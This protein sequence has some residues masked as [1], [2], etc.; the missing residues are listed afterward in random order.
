MKTI[1]KILRAAFSL[2]LILSLFSCATTKSAGAGSNS[3]S[4]N[5][6]AKSSSA[7]AASLTSPVT[8]KGT[9]DGSLMTVTFNT[10]GTFDMHTNVSTEE[11]GFSLLMDLDVGK[12]TFTGDPSTDGEITMTVLKVA[13][14]DS[15]EAGDIAVAKMS[16]VLSSG[17]NTIEITNDD[18][19][20]V[21]YKGSAKDQTMTFVIS[22]GKLD[23]DGAIL[24]R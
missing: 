14:V 9:V 3:S 12:G 17:G 8:Y 20:L 21:D 11:A 5:T 10:D 13:D 15:D 16:Q 4:K 6:S 1:K 18:L 23:M 24:S 7:K 19:P 2:G 22:D